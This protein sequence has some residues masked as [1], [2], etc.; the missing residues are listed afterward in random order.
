MKQTN[1]ILVLGA[2]DNPSRMSCMALRFLYNKGYNLFAVSQK[3]GL[4]DNTILHD[5]SEL[6][7][8]KDVDLVTVFLK[9][10][11]QRK[12]YNYLLS[13][14]PKKIIFNPGT[15]NPEFIALL[16]E[17][18]IAIVTGCTIALMSNGSL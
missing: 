15:E 18:N 6:L 5:D 13:L 7:L 9:P 10:E 12:Y 3:K 4:V 17:K 14:N 11:R 1:N 8:A 2:S 16:T